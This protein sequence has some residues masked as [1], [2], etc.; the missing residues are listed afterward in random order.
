MTNGVAARLKVYS[1][2]DLELIRKS[3]TG[4]ERLAWRHRWLTVRE[5]SEVSGLSETDLY[6]KAGQPVWYL[7]NKRLRCCAACCPGW[8]TSP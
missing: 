6:R 8:P 2:D 4:G 1:Q 3:S 5:A 7:D